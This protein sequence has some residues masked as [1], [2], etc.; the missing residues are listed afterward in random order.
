EFINE[1]PD[2]FNT[3][4]GEQGEGLSGGQK[5]RIAL[6]RAFLKHAPILMLDE[7][8]AHLDSQTEQLIQNAIAEYAKNHLVITIA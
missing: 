4:I 7:P 2:G 8:T 6:A 5:Q 3:L 1:L